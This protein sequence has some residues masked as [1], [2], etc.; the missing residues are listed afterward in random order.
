MISELVLAGVLLAST[1]P[2]G[3]TFLNE[4]LA[5]LL[6]GQTIKV[7]E[8]KE[9]MKIPLHSLIVT[10]PL[11]GVVEDSTSGRAEN[12]QPDGFVTVTW[13]L[14]DVNEQFVA[15][16]FQEYTAVRMFHPFV[17]RG[18]E[19]VLKD[20]SF[21]I[22]LHEG[23]LLHL[24]NDMPSFPKAKSFVSGDVI[25]IAT[26]VQ[27]KVFVSMDSEVIKTKLSSIWSDSLLCNGSIPQCILGDT[28]I[29]A[30]NGMWV[31]N[32]RKLKG[33][34]CALRCIWGETCIKK[35]DGSVEI[36][37]LAIGGPPEYYAPRVEKLS[38]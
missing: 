21:S 12:L 29:Q 11:S 24:R 38:K 34:S 19:A 23:M 30:P 9:G 25:G 6:K 32:A 22:T 33:I 15:S 10:S 28:C 35:P 8:V 5:H 16:L 27:G 31:K 18:I 7:E 14:K 36:R 2:D 17:D 4:Y 26:K 20:D 3:Q 37:A 1:P 13:K